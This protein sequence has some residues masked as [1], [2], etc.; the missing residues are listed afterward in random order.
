[1]PKASDL[2]RISEHNIGRSD[3]VTD[4]YYQAQKRPPKMATKRHSRVDVV[5]ISKGN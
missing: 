5:K 3:D 2:A 4:A 1:M